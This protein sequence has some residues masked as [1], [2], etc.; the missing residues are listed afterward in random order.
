MN[1]AAQGTQ[2]KPQ[3]NETQRKLSKVDQIIR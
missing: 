1:I 3:K 2:C